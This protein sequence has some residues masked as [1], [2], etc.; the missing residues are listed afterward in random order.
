M[1]KAC[2]TGGEMNN[3]VLI[4]EEKQNGLVEAVSWNPFI[5]V[6]IFYPAL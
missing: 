2:K 4:I 5:N 6:E 3:R 1:D